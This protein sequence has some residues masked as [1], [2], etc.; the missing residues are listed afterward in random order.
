[1]YIFEVHRESSK[2][3]IEKC[4]GKISIWLGS[5]C[6]CYI[7]P[8]SFLVISQ[9]LFP[10]SSDD[11]IWRKGDKRVHLEFCIFCSSLPYVYIYIG[12]HIYVVSTYIDFSLDK[13]SFATFTHSTRACIFRFKNRKIYFTLCLCNIKQSELT[14]L[15]KYTYAFCVD[16]FPH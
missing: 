11:F 13:N 8:S 5:H 7:S 3:Y 14:Y 2:V 15:E 9:V 4:E 12:I 1:M 6:R 16:S 10:S